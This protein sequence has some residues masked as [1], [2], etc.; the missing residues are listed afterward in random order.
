MTDYGI[1]LS[2]HNTVDDWNAV[3]GNNITYASIKLTQ[4]TDFVDWAAGN[5]VAG[6][7]SV[8]IRPG[9]YHYAT[10]LGDVDAQADRFTDNLRAHGLLDAGSLAPMLDMEAADLRGNA[11]PFV[12]EFIARYRIA[13][14]QSKI[15]VY[16]N[17]DWWTHVLNP[18]EWADDDVF[19]WI[20]RYNGDPGNPGWNHPRLALHQHTNKG[21]VP[22]IPGNVDRDAT[23]AGFGLD[24]L[25]LG[26]D[27]P[28]PPPP[29]PAPAPDDTYT[30]QS[31]DTLSGIAA[32]F[33]T[34][35]QE[36]Q[37]INGIPN[38][39]LIFPGQVLRLHGD[40][41]P[42]PP[43]EPR[44]YTVVRGDTLS[45]IAARFG[46]TWR[47]LQEINGIANPNLIF[48]GQVLRLP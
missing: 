39:N 17:L 20:A 5:H 46:T 32:R 2:H 27:A 16:A 34:T 18:D 6:A 31:G 40:P 36:L 38:A 3:R 7:R 9:G 30:V 29:P 15:L 23:M 37:R 45:G 47:T 4:S 33:G 12:R 8:G 10:G 11:N 35:W 14:G 26:G 43:D 22:G 19:L 28:A 44:T 41:A 24:T 25:T 1:D 42:P 21:T 13:S 48:P